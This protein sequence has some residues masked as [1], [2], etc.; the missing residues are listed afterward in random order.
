[1]PQEMVEPASPG[2]IHTCAT[3][4]R[5]GGPRKL[6]IGQPETMH[7]ADASCMTLHDTSGTQSCVFFHFATFCQIAILTVKAASFSEGKES[8]AGGGI[9]PPTRGFS[10]LCS[11]N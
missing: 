6:G 2:Q 10:V 4:E 9:E 8:V 3:P 5:A 11:A 7:D 1:M